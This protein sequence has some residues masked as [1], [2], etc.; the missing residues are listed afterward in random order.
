MPQTLRLW[1]KSIN[2]FHVHS[3]STYGINPG[4]NETFIFHPPRRWGV[5]FHLALIIILMVIGGWGL[6]QTAYLGVGP[7]FLFYLFPVLMAVFGVPV[8][9]YRLN[10][11]QNSSYT[12]ERD[13]LRLQWGLR[14]EVL[15]TNAI[16][17]VRPATDLL[18][19]LRYPVLRWYGSVQGTRRLAGG[20]PVEFLASQTRDL[21][22]IGTYEKVFAVSPADPHDFLQAYQRLTELGSLIPPQPRSILPA[23][24]VARVWQTPSARNLILASFLL[25]LSLLI[26]VGLIAPSQVDVS[27]GFL[28]TGQP[29]DPIPGIRLL[30][31]PVLNGIFWVFDL[32][33][34]LVFFRSEER[35]PLAYLLWSTSILV[36]VL[37]LAGVY[38]IVDI[39]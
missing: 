26:W 35:R 18:E 21:I 10:T 22:L 11:L 8:L 28:P 32:L 19:K 27:L 17:W 29:R 39:R 36:S 2:G 37:F 33:A 5:I 34:G 30:L 25:G 20:T 3:H 1:G 31:L 4:V 14:V 15:P 9:I 6:F 38:F 7:T 24:I 12:L 16:L 13:S 23:F